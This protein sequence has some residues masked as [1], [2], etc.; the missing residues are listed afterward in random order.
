MYDLGGYGPVII[1]TLW[2]EAAIALVVVCMR[3]FTRIWINRVVGWDDFLIAFSCVSSNQY[4][5]LI[6]VLTRDSSC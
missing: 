3:L 2:T 6:C 5:E 4:L 1:V